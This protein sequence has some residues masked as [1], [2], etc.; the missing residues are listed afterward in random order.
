[1]PPLA[2][3]IHS[4]PRVMVR[5]DSLKGEVYVK[6]FLERAKGTPLDIIVDHEVPVGTV[7]LLSPLTKQIRSFDFLSCGWADIQRFQKSFL[8]R[9]R[10][11]T[12]SQSISRGRRSGR[13]REYPSLTTPLQQRR[14][15]E[16]SPLPFNLGSVAVHTPPCFSKPRL[17]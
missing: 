3:N 11:C 17:V 12:P 2:Q 8:D 9:S 4:M 7:A 14:K 1:M 10:S 6:T 13:L 16:G 5:V 15:S